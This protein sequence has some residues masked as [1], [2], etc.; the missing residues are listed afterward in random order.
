M[1]NPSEEAE[2]VQDEIPAFAMVAAIDEAR[3][4]G[5]EGDLPWHIPADLKHFARTTTETR[6]EDAMN[7]VIMGRLTC[8]SIPEK[9]WPLKGRANAVITRNPSWS[10]EQASVFADLPSALR[11]MRDHCERLFVVGGGQIYSLAIELAACEELIL[12]RIRKRFRCDAFFP[13]YEHAFSCAEVL[14][15]GEHKGLAYSIE[16]W[17]R[18]A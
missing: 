13:E 16:R 10:K 2:G 6:T 8:E 1:T 17:T 4:L 14:S 11:G 12:T 18:T 9:F 5:F 3:G 7:A 15:E